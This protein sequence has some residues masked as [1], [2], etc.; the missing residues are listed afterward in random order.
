MILRSMDTQPYWHRSTT[1]PAYPPPAGDLET[2]A[3]VI[4]GGITGVTTAYLLAKEGLRTVLVERE[5]LGRRDT[6]HTTAHLT[7]MTDTRL[8]DLV[9]TFSRR[10]ARLAWEAGSAAMEL[11]RR[12]VEDLEIACELQTVPGFLAAASD[13]DLQEERPLLQEEAVLARQLGFDATYVE[14]APVTDRPGI[15]FG[16]QMMF[17]PLLYLQQLASHAVAA[18]ARIFGD[19]EVTAFDD[20]DGSVTAGPVKIRYKHV[21]I[22]THVPMQGTCGTTGAT[23]FQ[24]KLAAYSTYAIGA[25]IPAGAVK[26]MIWSDTADPFHYLRVGELADS[27]YAILGGEDHRTGVAEDTDALYRKL[28]QKLEKIVPGAV[29]TDRWSGQVVETVD[30]LPYIGD[31]GDG[32]FIA[33]G[34]SGNGMTFGTVAAMMARDFVTGRKNPWTSVF[35]PGRKVFGSMSTYLKENAGYPVRMVTDRLKVEEGS[36][37][38]LEPGTGKVLE[39]DGKRVAACRDADGTLH[40]MSAVCPHMGCIVAWNGAENTWDCPCHGSRFAADG[41]V[42]AGPAES[43]LKSE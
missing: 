40:V 16:G 36:P 30:C 7:Y 38:D 24:S 6:G 14:R 13:A 41:K 29:V 39:H 21:I 26:H 34:Y 15:R 25:R 9:A 17:H 28:E 10:E 32:Q 22:A 42:I 35:D 33:T 4:G 3:L 18:G 5:Q 1:V 27:D 19:T 11:I 37:G 8:S 31:V 12:H 23:L 20:K 43:D 2:D